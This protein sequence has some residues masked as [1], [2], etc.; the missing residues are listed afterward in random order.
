MQIALQT[1]DPP[2]HRVDVGILEPRK[3]H[4]SMEVHDLR[5]GAE[6]AAD[7]S[8]AADGDDPAVPDA[9]RARPSA[10]RIHGVHG[11]VHEGEVGRAHRRSIAVTRARR[12]RKSVV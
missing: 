9:D 11:A 1:I 8:V 4:A 6:L 7:V 5:R 3:H 2:A 10:S 12:G